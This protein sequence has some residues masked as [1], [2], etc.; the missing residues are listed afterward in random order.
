MKT[1]VDNLSSTK[2]AEFYLRGINK[3]SD[4]WYEAIQNDDEQT[5]DRNEFIAKILM[6]KLYF[7]QTEIMTQ[8]NIYL[9]AYRIGYRFWRD[10][11]SI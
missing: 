9:M 7:I 4:E 1:F 6:N 5:I 3:P 8:P 2:P 11:T 10:V